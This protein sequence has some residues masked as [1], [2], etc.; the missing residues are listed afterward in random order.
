MSHSAISLI[1]SFSTS[2]GGEVS[3][4]MLLNEMQ[5]LEGDYFESEK[6]TSCALIAHAGHPH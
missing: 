2:R 6:S 3:T 1:Y 5:G 4:G